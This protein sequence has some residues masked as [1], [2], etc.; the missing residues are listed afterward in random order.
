MLVFLNV[1][2]AKE[3][4]EAIGAIETTEITEAIVTQKFTPQTLYFT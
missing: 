4:I 2:S 1:H 3:A